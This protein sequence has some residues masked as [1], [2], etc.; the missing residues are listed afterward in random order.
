MRENAIQYKKEG[1]LAFISLHRPERHNALNPYVMRRLSQIWREYALDRD[2]RAA[3]L[4][5]EGPSFCSGMDLKECTPGFGY[6]SETIE[7]VDSAE[8]AAARA[9]EARPGEKRKMNYVPPPD[10]CKPLIGALHG[11]VSGGGLELALSCDIRIAAEGTTFALPEVTRGLVPGSGGMVW[12]PR[13]V[14]AGRA[15]EWL[16]TGD[17]L[18]CEEAL[19]IGLVNRVVPRDRLLDTATD[20]AG[21][22]AANA[23]LAAQAIKETVVRSLG[24]S[25][26]EGLALSEQ[27]ARVLSKTSDYLEGA[28]A[29]QEKRPPVFRG[30]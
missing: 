10:L 27:Q 7:G 25:I 11:R 20:L 1:H 2:L 15:L 21:R 16:L 9:L 12:L 24:T 18:D 30:E 6:R 14:G 26:A 13:I 19:R 4:Y 23:P 8:Y 22:I 29:F 28:R 17:V 5:G 3:V